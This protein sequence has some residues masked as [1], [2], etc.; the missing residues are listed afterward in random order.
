MSRP[1]DESGLPLDEDSKC[2]HCGNIG[3][4]SGHP[5]T[6]CPECGRWSAPWLNPQSNDSDMSSTPGH[7]AAN[8]TLSFDLTEPEGER[9]LRECLDA[10]K[11]KLVLWGLDQWARNEIKYGPGDETTAPWANG[12]ADGLSMARKKLFELCDDYGIRLD[13][14]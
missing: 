13:E 3:G 11:A 14:E 12:V 5:A 6:K 2:R 9:R 7:T 1:C 4:H 8:A 10:P